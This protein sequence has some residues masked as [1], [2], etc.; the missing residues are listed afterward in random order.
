M[1]QKEYQAVRIRKQKRIGLYGE[2]E[3]YQLYYRLVVCI[4]IVLASNRSNRS[5]HEVEESKDK[6][7]NAIGRVVDDGGADALR[8]VLPKELIMPFTDNIV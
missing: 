3:D 6:A 8:G 2:N 1:I 4:L 5:N 7:G